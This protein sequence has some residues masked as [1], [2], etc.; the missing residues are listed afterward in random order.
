MRSVRARDSGALRAVVQQGQ[1]HRARDEGGDPPGDGVRRR[2]AGHDQQVVA[3]ADR[4]VRPGKPKNVPG[5]GAPPLRRAVRSW[6]PLFPRSRRPSPAAARARALASGASPSGRDGAPDLAARSAPPG[7]APRNSTV[8]VDHRLGHRLHGVRGAQGREL[9]GLDHVRRD[10]LGLSIAIWWANR[11]TA[12]QCGQVGVTKTCRWRG[13]G[14]GGQA[15]PG[16]RREAG[17]AAGDVDQV[18]QHGGELVA[19]GEAEEAHRAAAGR[20]R[21]DRRAPP[22]PPRL[23]PRAPRPPGRPAR[24][25]SQGRACAP[26]RAPGP[27]P[28][29]RGGC[30]RPGAA[31]GRGPT[32]SSISWPGLAT[33][34]GL[35]PARDVEPARGLHEEEQVHLPAQVALQD[36]AQA[37]PLRRPDQAQ[38]DP[39]ASARSPS[40]QW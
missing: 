9:V 22:L 2:R 36:G 25:G 27:G 12:G 16:G 13:A 30:R 34:L 8:L 19:G 3:D 40:P 33:R 7:I 37:L 28:A 39:M 17:L 21:P 18:L 35:L 6:P 11:A 20:G 5:R 23:P 1:R 26:R 29:R 14:R 4:P 38:R 15:L 31:S 10:P 32:S 24:A